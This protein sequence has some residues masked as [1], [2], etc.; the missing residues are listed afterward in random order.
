MFG[1]NWNYLSKKA[2]H[3][4]NAYMDYPYL[5]ERNRKFLH[6]WFKAINDA[7]DCITIDES[8]G[9]VSVDVIAS[10]RTFI[11]NEIAEFNQYL[12]LFI[13]SSLIAHDNIKLSYT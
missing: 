10:R 2:V 3:A 4:K 12:K 9:K 7:N 8:K 13:E 11:N 1:R 5:D 6:A